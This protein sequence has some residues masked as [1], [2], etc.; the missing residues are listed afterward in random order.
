MKPPTFESHKPQIDQLWAQ[1]P[2]AK[3]MTEVFDS[4]VPKWTYRMNNGLPFPDPWPPEQNTKFVYYI[5]AVASA[6]H[7]SGA[8]VQA[9]PW[10]RITLSKN[11]SS[12]VEPLAIQYKELGRQGVRPVR[13]DEIEIMK[14][15]E[16]VWEFLGALDALPSDTDVLIVRTRAYYCLWLRNNSLLGNVYASRHVAFVTWLNCEKK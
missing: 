16:A 6:P 12:N 15:G 10:A 9:E 1:T 2:L 13:S 5:H 8:E 11:G 14:H 3:Q 4:S 7:I